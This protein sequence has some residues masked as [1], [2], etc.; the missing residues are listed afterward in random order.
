MTRIIR[1]LLLLAPVWLAG[2][3]GSQKEKVQMPTQQVPPIQEKP[4]A[5][6]RAD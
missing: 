5:P 6:S 3:G 1:I 2:C 4:E